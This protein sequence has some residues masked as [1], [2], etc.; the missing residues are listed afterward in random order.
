MMAESWNSR[1]I[2]VIHFWATARTSLNKRGILGSGV[3]YVVHAK[4]I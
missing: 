4:V 2:K 3:F 1:P